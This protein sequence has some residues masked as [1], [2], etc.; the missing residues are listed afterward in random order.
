MR[1]VLVLWLLVCALVVVSS[2][3]NEAE[4]DAELD[5][6]DPVCDGESCAGE[7]EA[8]ASRPVYKAPAHNAPPSESINSTPSKKSSPNK[9]SSTK[10]STSRVA[11]VLN[12]SKTKSTVVGR[13][14]KVN[15][16][17]KNSKSTTTPTLKTSNSIKKVTV[18]SKDDGD[19]NQNDSSNIITKSRT[20]L[21]SKGMVPPKQSDSG[22]ESSDDSLNPG[23]DSDLYTPDV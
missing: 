7:Y 13:G 3:E 14:N 20:K 1:A 6:E 2:A 23:P 15:A 17:T 21:H 4:L 16:N 5:R 12:K 18:K 11:S 22:V 19:K 10:K 8:P 9:T